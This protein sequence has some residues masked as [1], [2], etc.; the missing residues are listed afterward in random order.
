MLMP[1]C[2]ATNSGMKWVY[3]PSSC[4]ATM[5]AAGLPLRRQAARAKGSPGGPPGSNP[6]SSRHG[7]NF[8][9][10]LDTG[11]G[12]IVQETVQ[13]SRSE[14]VHA[15][16]WIGGSELPGAASKVS[17]L[18]RDGSMLIAF[19]KALKASRI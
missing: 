12:R 6:A 4:V 18:A 14:A 1:S 8:A 15:D 5:T 17:E 9:I 11:D 3:V 19:C 10:F 13:L 16:N 2:T 7:Q